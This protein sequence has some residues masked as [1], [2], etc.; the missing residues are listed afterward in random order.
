MSNG[1]SLVDTLDPGLAFVGFDSLVVS[2]PAAVTTSVGGGFPAVLTGGSVSNPG[3]A[4]PVT[5]GSRVTFNFDSVTNTDTNSAVAET[6]TL[7]YRAV[8][9]NSAT[10]VR[11]QARNNS[12]AW[13]AGGN[14]VTASAPDVT[15]VE[16]SLSVNKIAAPVN[17]DAND[18][19]T[20]TVVVAHAGASN[21][22]AFD[23]ALADP[24]PAG[25]TVTAGPTFALGLASTSLTISAGTVTGPGPRSRSARPRRS[26]SRARSTPASRLAQ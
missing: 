16:P 25:I 22:D 17:G 24:I 2:N 13:T 8:V 1:V 23:V 14:T 15:L 21:T 9:L 11:G 4:S 3:G 18:T 12:A 20:F 5:A 7:T 19:V 6:I 26:P 10:N